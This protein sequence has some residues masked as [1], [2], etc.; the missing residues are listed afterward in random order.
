MG[1]AYVAVAEG[2]SAAYYN[3]AGLSALTRLNVGGMYSEPYGEEFGITFQYLSATGPLGTQTPSLAGVGITWLGTMVADIPIWEE[4]G[5]AGTFN[6]TSSL[7][8]A[9]AATLI[10]VLTN[11]SVG[12][13]AKYYT[14][15]MLEGRAEGLG[16]DV[17]ALGA[18]I[19]AEIPVKFGL[20]AMDVGRTN[21]RW[22][23]MSGV[24]DNYVSWVNKVG[25]SASL[26]DGIALVACDF[27]WAVGRPLQEQKL[28]LGVEVRAVDELFLR[29]GWSSE[30][31]GTGTVTVGVGVRAFDTFSMDY[32]Y[33]PKRVFGETHL[34]SVLFAF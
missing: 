19:I 27:D 29:G 16:W 33:L 11:W 5:P 32:A 2:G 34:I 31:E 26:F 3:P 7:Y 25:F 10:P 30:L 23:T 14:A 18:F 13:S 20:N 4:E 21:V 24:T 6:A 15:R 22:R 8:L 9:S 28:Y 1:G 17:G 12:V